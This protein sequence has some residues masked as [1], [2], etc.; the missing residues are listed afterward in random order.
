MLEAKLCSAEMRSSQLHVPP[1]SAC[2]DCE[3]REQR[4]QL[5]R[6]HGHESGHGFDTVPE[7]LQ[8][9]VFILGVL[10]VVVVSDRNRDRNRLKMIGYDREWKA[11]T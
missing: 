7:V 8:S 11:S 1:V 2:D 10:V 4:G 3:G 5:L 9:D 6:I